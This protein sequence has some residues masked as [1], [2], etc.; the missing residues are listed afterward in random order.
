MNNIQN[1]PDITSYD[2]KPSNHFDRPAKEDAESVDTNL[3]VNE[4][5]KN[6]PSYFSDTLAKLNRSLENSGTN[7]KFGI[8]EKSKRYYFQIINTE[9]KQVIKQYPPE[10]ILEVLA[11]IDEM[12]GLIVDRN[13]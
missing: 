10:E 4:K 6:D 2:V 5:L 12:I 11:K 1:K 8:D 13:A 7:L 9:S 3:S